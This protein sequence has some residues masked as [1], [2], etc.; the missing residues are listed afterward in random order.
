M[1]SSTTCG[2]GL[3]TQSAHPVNLILAIAT[4][5][6]IAVIIGGIVVGQYPSWIGVPNCD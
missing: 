2:R 6:K 5:A 4:L 1:L 3:A